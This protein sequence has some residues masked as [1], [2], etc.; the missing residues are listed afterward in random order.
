MKVP[1]VA[2]YTVDGR[3]TE[4]AAAFELEARLATSDAPSILALAG[5][6]RGALVVGSQ[7]PWAKSCR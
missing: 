6:E 2:Q 4:V 5:P 1:K 7:L 3:E